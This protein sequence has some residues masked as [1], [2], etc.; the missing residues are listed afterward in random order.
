MGGRKRRKEER[1]EGRGGRGGEGRG[2]REAMT[3]AQHRPRFGQGCIM[4]VI[5]LTSVSIQQ[6]HSRGVE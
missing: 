5:R 1:R 4:V 6:L 3:A 2:G